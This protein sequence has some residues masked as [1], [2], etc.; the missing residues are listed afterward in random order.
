METSEMFETMKVLDTYG[1][2]KQGIPV[3]IMWMP[4]VQYCRWRT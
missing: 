4:N 1:N 2:R 3:N